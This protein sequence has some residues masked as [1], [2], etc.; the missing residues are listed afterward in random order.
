MPS[1]AARSRLR[2]L[3]HLILVALAACSTTPTNEWSP[4]Q[5]DLVF[6]SNRGGNSEIY[7]IRGGTA[8]WINLTR[9][10]AGENW[11]VWSPDGSRIAYQRRAPKGD[12]DQLDIWVMDADGSNRHALTDNPAH[13]YLPAWS[14]DGQQLSFASWRTEPG[15][16]GEAAVHIYVMNADGSGQRRLFAASLGL[17][18]G[19][20]WAA[21]GQR[22]LVSRKTGDSSSEIHITDGAGNTNR[23]LTRD[24]VWTG[25]PVFSPTGSRIAFYADDGT[26]SDIKVM[27]VDGTYLRTVLAGGKHYYPRWSPDGRWLVCTTTLPGDAEG[28]LSLI[29]VPVDGNAEPITLV[30]GGGRNAE[31]AWRPASP[32]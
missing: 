17:S 2:P 4:A 8:E 16:V 3:A 6:S 14:P 21:D 15:D 25:A 1:F 10:E 12:S 24:Q 32:R 11:P 5:A 18:A 30:S 7:L 20:E 26:A 27:N 31:G 13:D 19:A 9:S 28:D 29:A 22:F 23:R